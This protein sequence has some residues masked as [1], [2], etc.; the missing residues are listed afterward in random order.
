[1]TVLISISLQTFFYNKQLSHLRTRVFSLCFSHGKGQNPNPRHKDLKKDFGI[2]IKES[3]KKTIKLSTISKL[4][5][6]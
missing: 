3:S 5:G 2:H 1:M 4:K 6:F